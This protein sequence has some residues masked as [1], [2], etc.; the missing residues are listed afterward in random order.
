M[1][2]TGF[3]LFLLFPCLFCFSQNISKDSTQLSVSFKVDQRDSVNKA[4]IETLKLFLA[5]KNDSLRES[6]YWLPSDFDRYIT[7]YADI[8]DIEVSKF[9]KNYYKPSLMEIIPTD[10]SSRFVVKLAFI[11][12]NDEANTNVIKAIY[13]IVATW[14]NGRIIFSKY[15]DYITKDWKTL[16]EGSIM[17]KISPYKTVSKTDIEKQKT[18][19]LRLCSFFKTKP[20]PI[21]Y[22][23]CRNP[24]EVFELK[25]FDYHPMMYADTSGGFAEDKNIVISGNNAEYY[26]HEITH[27]YLGKLFPSIKMFFNEGFA[28]YT[29]G[30]GKYAY[31]WQRK[32][33]KSF[34][35]KNPDF[36]FDEHMDVH[37]W[38]YFERETPV[39]YVFAALVC[40]RTLRLYGKE[41]LFE[42]FQSNED[43]IFN[44]LQKAGLTREN[45]NAELRKELQRPALLWYQSLQ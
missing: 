39:P 5:S 30:S 42:L 2:R 16:G 22:Y 1:K 11:G 13:N 26:T 31:E 10:N 15:I 18:D 7:P 27:L 19:I 43:D 4:I 23:S 37:E 29:G 36:K 40:E 35:D 41:K 20:L 33:L 45:M 34:I 38:L 28:T 12:H 14:H 17:Y 8:A 24:K 3:L 9:G 44:I 21:T 25:G 32:K 6:K